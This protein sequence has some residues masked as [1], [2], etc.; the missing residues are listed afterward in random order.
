MPDIYQELLKLADSDMYPLHMPGH[1]RNLESTP[2]KGAFRCDITE[3]DGFDNLHD[4]SGIILE[5]ERRANDLYGADETFFLVNG[6]TSG[7]LSAVSAAVLE[8][9]RILA[10]RGS[11]RSFYHAAYLRHL[12]VEYLPVKMIDKYGIFDGYSAQEVQTALDSLDNQV[13]AVFITSPTYEGKCSD[14]AGIARVCHDRNI[15]LIVDAAHGAHFGLGKEI[16]ESAVKLGADVVIHSLHKTLP[17]MTQTALI[18]LQG[19][20]VDKALLK[21]FLRIYQ[22]S[23]PSYV[24]MSS[25]DLCINEL[26][27]KKETYVQRL[28]EHRKNLE[29]KTRGCEKVR[30]IHTDELEDPSKVL[31]FVD[32]EEMTGH[33]LYDILR[34][35]YGLQLEMAGERYGLAIITGWDTDEGI[36]R[37]SK[38]I[39]EIDNRLS[40][41]KSRH[42]ESGKPA[43]IPQKQMPLFEAWDSDSEAVELGMAKGRIAGDFVNLYPPGIPMIVP[44]EVIDQGLIDQIEGCIEQGLNVQGIFNGENRGNKGIIIRREIICVKQK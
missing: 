44:G 10:A 16:P 11:H 8:G 28:L 42:E 17:A 12:D 13:E 34:E 26:L 24:L 22:S 40:D 38:A 19:S 2:L 39:C 25:I 41:S 4:E 1:K 31:I 18:H 37:L 20:L 27:E 29:L 30:I 5:A 43:L 3:I 21:R 32:S 6:S 9:G 36:D 33:Q 7:V 14:V 23:S 35:E 15:P